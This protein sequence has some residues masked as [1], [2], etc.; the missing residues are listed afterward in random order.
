VSPRTTTAKFKQ[1]GALRAASA[2]LLITGMANSIHYAMLA[3]A[4]F[5]LRPGHPEAF[6]DLQHAAMWADG[7]MGLMAFAG[8][9]GLWRDRSW[10]RLFG[11]VSAAAL[12]LMGCLDVAFFAQ[13]GMYEQ[14][15]ARMLEMIVVDTWAFGVGSWLVFVLWNDQ[16]QRFDGMH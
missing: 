5:P 13:H 16:R 7:W 9:W 15:D 4:G 14:L 12:I 8:A 3:A 10:G 11:I 1:H 2:A 6:R